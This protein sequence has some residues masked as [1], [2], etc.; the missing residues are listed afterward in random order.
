MFRLWCSKIN[1]PCTLSKLH[2]CVMFFL[3]YLSFI[4]FKWFADWITQFF[5]NL[6]FSVYFF[7]LFFYF[8]S[9]TLTFSS[10]RVLVHFHCCFSFIF[11]ILFLFFFLFI[12]SKYYTR[13]NDFFPAKFY[14]CLFHNSFSFSFSLYL[15][16]HDYYH[17][18][19][20]L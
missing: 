6:T 10:I 16:S 13:S 20:R 11:F 17:D 15:F 1:H 19:I 8:S 2:K 5:N 3:F 12:F 4:L 18:F 9:F 14:L 7:S